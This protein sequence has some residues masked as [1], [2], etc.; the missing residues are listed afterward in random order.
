MKRARITL[1]RLMIVVAVVAVDVA[2]FIVAC[3]SGEGEMVLGSH[4]RG[5]P[6]R[7]G[8]CAPF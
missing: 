2:A 7:S 5:L 4:Q 1:A 8:S 3:R 6:A